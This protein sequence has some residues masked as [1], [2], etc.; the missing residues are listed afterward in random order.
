MQCMNKLVMPKLF[1]PLDS[2]NMK[3]NSSIN[4]Y[5]IFVTNYS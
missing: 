1:F 3:N 2:V 4:Y 5:V